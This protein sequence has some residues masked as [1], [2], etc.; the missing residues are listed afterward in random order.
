[1]SDKIADR[2]ADYA[3]KEATGIGGLA[4]GN[5]AKMLFS[6]LLYSSELNKGHDEELAERRLPACL[7]K[8]YQPWGTGGAAK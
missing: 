7:K 3:L 1:M 6:A 8:H 5:R 4:T 2:I